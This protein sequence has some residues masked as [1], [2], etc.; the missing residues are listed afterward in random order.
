MNLFKNVHES[1]IPLLHSLAYKEPMV[2]FLTSLNEIS[3]QPEMSQIFKVFEMS[4]Q[5]IKVVIL[6]Q[7]P[8]PIPGAAI[9]TAYAVSEKT[10]I[11][12]ILRNIEK[13]VYKT[14]GVR[15]LNDDND[16]VDQSWKTLTHWSNQG[17]FLLNTA[18]TVETGNA[19]SH[20]KYWKEF[21]DMVISFISYEN[22]C[23]WMLWGDYARIRGSKIKNPFLVRGYDRISIE[24]IP[25]DPELNYI[26]PGEHP[27][28]VIEE[29]Q[30]FSKDGFYYTNRILEKRSLKKIIW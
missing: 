13:E 2:N 30:G 1:W 16:I 10:K 4:V 18:L 7:D 24:D 9:G 23:T 27:A 17:V 15:V 19:G 26:I 25:I 20:I 6:G 14:K 29:G 3:F 22:P 5:D 11:P 8:Y 21:T 12:F 28:K